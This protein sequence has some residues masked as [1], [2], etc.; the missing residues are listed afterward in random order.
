MIYK[1]KK[2]KTDINNSVK[3]DIS[4]SSQAKSKKKIEKIA[5]ISDC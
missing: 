1:K 5:A 3:F 4:E 2:R